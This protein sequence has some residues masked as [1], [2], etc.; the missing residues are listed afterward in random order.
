MTPALK[1]PNFGIYIKQDASDLDDKR[2]NQVLSSFASQE[3][4]TENLQPNPKTRNDIVESAAV[5]EAEILSS[6]GSS[7]DSSLQEGD[8]EEDLADDEMD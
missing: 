3:V 4:Y 5:D 8:G 1:L 7:K 6:S 2:V